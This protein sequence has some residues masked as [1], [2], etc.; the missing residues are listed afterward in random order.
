MFASA[1]DFILLKKFVEYFEIPFSPKKNSEIFSIDF[2]AFSIESG[3]TSLKFLSAFPSLLI[4]FAIFNNDLAFLTAFFLF[5]F[6]TA[7]PSVLNNN[8]VTSD[9][10]LMLLMS[11]SFAPFDICLK[12]IPKGIKAAPSEAIAVNPRPQ[13]MAPTTDAII[14]PRPITIPPSVSVAVA[15]TPNCSHFK[16][17][18]EPIISLIEIPNGIKDAPITAIAIA[19]S[20][21]NPLLLRTPSATVAPP[22]NTIDTP[23]IAI[24]SHSTFFV[25]ENKTPRPRPRPAIPRLIQSIDLE[26]SL[27]LSEI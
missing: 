24:C 16:P 12:P 9:N 18:T 4:G 10:F 13:A 19:P 23:I 20:I 27:I 14:A 17:R 26:P 11:I 5:F 25:N 15:N 7:S 22:K 21:I 3:A 8:F 2:I 1:F 6:P